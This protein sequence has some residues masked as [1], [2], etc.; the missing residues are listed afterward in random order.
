MLRMHWDPEGR[1]RR[2]TIAR[3]CEKISSPGLAPIR[4]HGQT[5]S[6]K[7]YKVCPRTLMPQRLLDVIAAGPKA[8]DRHKSA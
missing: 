7:F 4:S 6:V 3:A 5:F 2:I 8:N 1:P